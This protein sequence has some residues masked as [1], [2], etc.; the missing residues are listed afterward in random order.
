MADIQLTEEQMKAIFRED[1][2]GFEYE[3]IEVGEWTDGGKYQSS[4]VVF[5]IAD[6]RCFMF[7]VIRSGSYFSHYEYE[8]PDRNI[9]EVKKAVVVTESEE[10]VD[11]NY[12]ESKPSPQGS[13]IGKLF[14]E[15]PFDSSLVDQFIYYKKIEKEIKSRLESI[16]SVATNIVK[17][18]NEGFYRNPTGAVQV[19]KKTE[20]R[21][22]ESLKTF[23]AERGLLDALRK[24]DIDLKKVDDAVKAGL[25]EEEELTK[26]IVKKDNSYLKL[27]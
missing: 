8:F 2:A 9:E 12:V 16:K 1:D 11:I 17:D 13:K 6:G 18:E 15:P 27:K 24:D 25:I 26:H 5:Q 20:R 21:A 19:V 22:K 4:Y 14:E 10:W 3:Q 7:E 23:L